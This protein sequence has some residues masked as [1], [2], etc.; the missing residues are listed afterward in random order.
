MKKFLAPSLALFAIVTLNSCI[1]SKQYNE[2]VEKAKKYETLLEKERKENTALIDE[3]YSLEDFGKG[4]SSELAKIQQKSQEA[5]D[6]LTGKYT[7]LQSDYKKIVEVNK[8]LIEEAKNSELIL[9]ATRQEGIR[10][11]A[12]LENKLRWVYVKYNVKR[13]ASN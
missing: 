1:S 7:Q 9:E 10:Q 11:V 3:K 4:K 8:K 13:S 12:D 6:V 5:I 2:A